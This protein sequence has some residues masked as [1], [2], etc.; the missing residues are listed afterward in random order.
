MFHNLR[1]N[2]DSIFK[3]LVWRAVRDGLPIMEKLAR[4]GIN[5][6]NR[7]PR[8]G[9]SAETTVH[10]V[11]LC[12]EAQVMWKLSPIRLNITNWTRSFLEWCEGH[13]KETNRQQQCSLGHGDDVCV[14]NLEL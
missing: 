4:H 7:C 3:N 9:D 13:V 8:C 11:L 1:F 14:A 5:V 12:K 6:D 10:M 2:C